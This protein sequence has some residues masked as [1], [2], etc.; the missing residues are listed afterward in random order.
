MNERVSVL[1]VEDDPAILDGVC[2][3]LTGEGYKVTAARNGR[4]AIERFNG[5]EFGL[6]ILDIMMPEKSGYDVC[7]EI[8]KLD[9]RVPVLFLSA[10]SEEVDKVVG[11]ELGADDYIVKPF[12]VHELLARIRALL[13]RSGL[14]PDRVDERM[15]V[16]G[17]VRIDSNTL[18]GTRGETGFELT[19]REIALVR[20]FVE[21]DGKVLARDEILERI[22]GT[23][24]EGTTRTLD[25]HIA[26]LRQKIEN[27][28]SKPS[29]IM[30][31]HTIGYRFVSGKSVME[32]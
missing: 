1:V 12:G 13:R 21:N 31:V 20:M 8:R 24:Y 7:R 6:V 16:F 18:R 17:D 3:L 10:K 19:H 27:D 26:K 25:Q 11:L 30:T 15:I 14:Q 29:L 4:E 5:C 32:S 9:S 22:W 2:D 23:K 28:P